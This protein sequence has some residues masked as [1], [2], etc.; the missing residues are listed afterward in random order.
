M[1]EDCS[2][3]ITNKVGLEQ[4][5][6]GLLLVYLFVFGCP[7]SSLLSTVFLWLQRAGATLHCSAQVLPE[8]LVLLWGASSGHVGFSSCVA[9]SVIGTGLRRCGT[10][11]QLLLSTWD[12]AHT[13]DQALAGE[14]SMTRPP[15]KSPRPSQQNNKMYSRTQEQNRKLPHPKGRFWIHFFLHWL[16][17]WCLF[18]DQGE[19]LNSSRQIPMLQAQGKTMQFTVLLSDSGAVNILYDHLNNCGFKNMIEKGPLQEPKDR[20]FDPLTNIYPLIYSWH[21]SPPSPT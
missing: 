1:T 15:G 3:E 16:W 13:R 21:S 19:I 10:P 7:G 14:S 18:G 17:H 9:G 6:P 12:L 8:R 4:D 2:P 11:T 5:F 20:T